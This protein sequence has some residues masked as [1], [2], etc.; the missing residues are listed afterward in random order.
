MLTSQGIELPEKEG[1]TWW[2]IG[3]LKGAFLVPDGWHTKSIVRQDTLGYYITKEK[4]VGESGT[5]E[6]GLSLNVFKSFKTKK[7]IAPESFIHDFQRGY[8]RKATILKEWNRDMGPFKSYGFL[9]KGIVDGVS[10]QIH[11]LFVA[12][13]KTETLYYF[14]FE[15]QSSEF[16]EAW[17]LGEPMMKM[18]LIDDTI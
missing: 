6:T 18:L 16:E 13:P 8:S 3:E 17:V 5:F 4:I 12:N 1:Y 15:A 2:E 9:S 14:F 10:T 7:G 11:H